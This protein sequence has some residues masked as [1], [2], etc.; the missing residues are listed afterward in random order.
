[1]AHLGETSFADRKNGSSASCTVFFLL[2]LEALAKAPHA[3]SMRAVLGPNRLDT[4][5][6]TVAKCKHYTMNLLPLTSRCVTI[7]KP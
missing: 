6:C 3:V 5:F 7:S 4:S 1:V 2:V